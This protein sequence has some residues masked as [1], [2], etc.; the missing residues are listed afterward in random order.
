MFP[1]QTFLH[2]NHAGIFR[3]GCLH[4]KTSKNMAL[5]DKKTR[6]FVQKNMETYGVTP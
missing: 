4:I 5:D 1:K 2:P 3:Q 6:E